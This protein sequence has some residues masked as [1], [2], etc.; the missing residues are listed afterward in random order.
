MNLF[1]IKNKNLHRGNSSGIQNSNVSSIDLDT[2]K[3]LL[4][5]AL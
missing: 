5:E 1:I 2:G 3:N 4:F